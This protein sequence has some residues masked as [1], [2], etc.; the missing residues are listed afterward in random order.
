MRRNGVQ[1]F[2]TIGLIALAG[3][4]LAAMGASPLVQALTSLHC[5]PAPRATGVFAGLE[6]I[7]AGNTASWQL[8]DPA[9]EI[10]VTF[11]RI[12]S[13]VAVL[14]VLGLTIWGV[15]LW[16]RFTES[17]A[18]FLYEMRSRSGL[19]QRGEVAKA[20]SAKQQLKR[21]ARL[22]PSLARPTIDEV[23]VSLGEARDVDVWVT[24]EDSLALLGS[25]RSGKGLYFLVGMILDYPGPVVTTSTRADN[26]ALTIRGRETVG[27]VGVFDPQGLSGL[28]GTMKWSPVAGCEDPLRAVQRGQA[29]VAGTKLGASNNNQ[30]WAEIAA[31]I[32]S[33]LLHAAA[34]DG[35]DAKTVMQWGS[36]PPLAIEAVEILEQYGPAGWADN[37]RDIL[38][39]TSETREKYWFGVHAALAPLRI[40]TV[41]EAMSP[42]PGEGFDVDEFLA[43]RN[44][45]YLIGTGTGAGA[46]GGFLGAL[47]DDITEQARRNALRMPGSRLDP[48]LGLILD[49]IA[50]IFTWPA[51]PQLMADGGGAGIQPV[52]V[53][54]ALSQAETVWSKAE[55]LTIWNAATAKI[56]LGGAG[57]ADF[58][59]DVVKLLG[60][61]TVRRKS[62]SDSHTGASFSEQETEEAVMSV[63]ELRRMPESISLMLSRTRRG[64]LMESPRWTKRPDAAAI[65]ASRKSVEAEQRGGVHV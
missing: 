12:V 29:I 64:V 9:C 10:P 1:D 13:A 18:Y 14:L 47:M 63:D 4:L 35:R 39:S 62:R 60:T 56:M 20:F 26:L 38:T 58:L 46:A 25:P 34:L 3:V 28:N 42:A 59:N 57:D 49:E 36:N 40:P 53:L 33:Q 16:W 21:A 19:A 27:R 52:V 37:L 2:G 30:E 54:Q 50:N 41:L 51:L 61:R 55:A 48:P 32:V 23:G 7:L 11:V 17:D 6:V 5:K 22:R 15:T 31:R 8:Q 43:G 45:L 24:I 65:T 44:T